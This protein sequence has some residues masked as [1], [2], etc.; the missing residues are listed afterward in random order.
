MYF[1]DYSL[2]GTTIVP[3]KEQH[4]FACLSLLFPI[5][6][7]IFFVWG[8]LLLFPLGNSTLWIFVWE[9]PFF[10]L[11]TFYDPLLGTRVQIYIKGYK[12]EDYWNKQVLNMIIFKQDFFLLIEKERT[13]PSI[14]LHC[15]H[16]HYKSN[17]LIICTMMVLP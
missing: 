14:S 3:S 9:H 8:F 10:P 15:P 6:N 16:F 7:N 11:L 1:L 2:Q 5:R 17:W 13:Q 12:Y 4:L